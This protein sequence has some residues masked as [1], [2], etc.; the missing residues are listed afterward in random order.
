MDDREPGTAPVP[1]RKR[2]WLRLRK[3][4]SNGERG[5][6][7]VEF[8]LILPVFLLLLFAMVD[9]G[10]AY[11]SW[12]VVTNAAREGARASAVRSDTATVNSKVYSSFCS[13]WP[14]TSNCGLEPGK[15]SVV[16]SNVQ[17]TRGTET[18]VKVTYNF[19]FVTP[20]G[21]IVSLVSGG[22]LATPTIN[23]TASMR[24]E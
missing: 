18:T 19:S 17:G 4:R 1:R 22:S 24:L 8:S 21:G 5:Q 13:T 10:R 7:L 16:P 2:G 20:I 15:V 11:Y 12:L 23:A 14:S 3:A 6:S 9:Y